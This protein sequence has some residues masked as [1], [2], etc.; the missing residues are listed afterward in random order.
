[1]AMTEFGQ[2]VDGHVHVIGERAGC[3]GAAERYTEMV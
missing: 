1:M 3:D 2:V